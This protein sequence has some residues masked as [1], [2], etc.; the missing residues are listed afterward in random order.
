[1]H[2]TQTLFVYLLG[3]GL[4]CINRLEEVEELRM[5]I[6]YIL[7]FFGICKY[8]QATNGKFFSPNGIA[9]AARLVSAGQYADVHCRATEQFH[10]RACFF[11]Q[12]NLR[13]HRSAE[14]E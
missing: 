2:N 5:I 10:A 14:N 4:K 7:K 8:H 12:N 6:K 13:F 9:H 3:Q 11:G 1:M